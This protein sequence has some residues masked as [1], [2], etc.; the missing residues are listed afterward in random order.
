MTVIDPFVD[1]RNAI[2][3]LSTADVDDRQ[4]I[5]HKTPTNTRLDP[6]RKQRT[7]IPEIIHAERK[8]PE[9]VIRSLVSLADANGR[10]IASRCPDITIEL[11][12]ARLSD[13]YDVTVHEMAR[14]VV[15]AQHNIPVQQTGGRVG[16]LSAGSSD[17]P[18]ATEAVVIAGEMGCAVFEARDVGVAGLHRL[19]EPL[20]RMVAAEVDVIV[21]AAGMDGALPSV[22]AGL[23]SVP[24]I[25]LPTSVGYGAG[26]EGTAALLAM[27][28]SCAPGLVVVN[29]DNGVG[30]GSTAALFANRVAAAR[31]ADQRA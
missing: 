3:N 24:V 14:L 4:Y 21:V 16:V 28:Q 26:G 6:Q 18:I 15:V 19:V 31:R 1:L 27:L 11:A 12:R 2:D 30:A 25:G 22:V 23:V 17:A 10:A 29:I 13:S 8:Q 20:G 5:S 9:E 7:G